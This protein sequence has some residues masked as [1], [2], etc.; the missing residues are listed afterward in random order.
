MMEMSQVLGRIP[1]IGS[2]PGGGDSQTSARQCPGRA[3]PEAL[4]RS[5]LSWGGEA[6]PGRQPLLLSHWLP[7]AVSSE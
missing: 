5:D 1:P 7:T 6:Q 2:L 3:V 4:I